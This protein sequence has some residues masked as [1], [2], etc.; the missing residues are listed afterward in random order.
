MTLEDQY[1]DLIRQVTV[2]SVNRDPTLVGRLF[3]L[4]EEM[5]AER[6]NLL[7]QSENMLDGSTSLHDRYNFR[8]ITPKHIGPPRVVAVSIE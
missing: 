5:G 2:E 7:L 4:A 1:L 8:T 6:L 3:K